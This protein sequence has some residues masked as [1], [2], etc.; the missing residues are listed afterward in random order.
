MVTDNP[1]GFW[2]IAS[3]V[4]KSVV[5]IAIGKTLD[6]TPN[7]VGTGFGIEWPECFATCWH[8]AEVEDKLKKLS[9]E[10]LEK[11]FQLAD[12]T[13]RIARLVKA[14]TYVW[15]EIEEKTWFR[16]SDRQ[17]DICIY[18][19]IGIPVL[20]LHLFH[21]EDYPWG[22]EVGVIGFP[23][24]N[25]LQGK[26]IRP[27]W[28]KTIIAGGLELKLE[29]GKETGRLALDSAFA[30]G[31]SGAPVFLAADGQ[32]VGMVASKTLESEGGQVW[33]TGISL[34]IPAQLIRRIVVSAMEKT[35]EII[36]DSLRKT[37]GEK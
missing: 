31:F 18:R 3:S 8:V 19:A 10:E 13:L 5:A 9:K 11:K 25:L 4:A 23:M 24:G 20:P 15:Q 2:E 17:A 7:I 14:D 16:V 35:T 36:K 37:I 30:G 26:I 22:A 6:G 29:G 12:T 27:L 1:R 21:E 32:V 34:A 33:P 28:S